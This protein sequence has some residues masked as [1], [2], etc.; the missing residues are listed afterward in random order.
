MQVIFTIE[1]QINKNVDSPVVIGVIA[2]V[3]FNRHSEAVLGFS[4]HRQ[5]RMRITITYSCVKI[6]KL[7]KKPRVW[8]LGTLWFRLDRDL[9]L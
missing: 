9:F 3:S 2:V 7:D 5:F 4:G 8:L 6:R 1:K